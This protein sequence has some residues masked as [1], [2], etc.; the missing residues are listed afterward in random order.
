[1]IAAISYSAT[2]NSCSLVTSAR[3]PFSHV[4]RHLEMM[5]CFVLPSEA[6]GVGVVPIETLP[7]SSFTA[8]GSLRDAV[9]P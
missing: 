9:A 2:L 6:T 8:S 1:M 4:R 3:Y 5:C 7:R